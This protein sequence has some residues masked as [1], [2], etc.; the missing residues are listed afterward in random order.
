[1]PHNIEPV[2]TKALFRII[3][4]EW[5]GEDEK[6]EIHNKELA[7]LFSIIDS[8]ESLIHIEFPSPEN[9]IPYPILWWKKTWSVASEKWHADRK[10]A[11]QLRYYWNV[12]S[13]VFQDL[14]TQLA[15]KTGFDLANK[16]QLKFLTEVTY[17]ILNK[18]DEKL[19]SAF[20]VDLSIIP[21]KP[22]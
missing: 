15:E 16:K 11:A 14:R 4:T 12:S 17:K 19:A 18:R 8:E 7:L 5:I 20:G 10:K 9:N 1:M 21:K 2:L 13:E 6:V 22:E 3:L